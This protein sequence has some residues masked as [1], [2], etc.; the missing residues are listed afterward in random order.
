MANVRSLVWIVLAALLTST[1]PISSDNVWWD[2]AR[3]RAVCHG[4]FQPSRSLLGQS[5][6]AESDWF[7]GVPGF[8]VYSIAGGSGLMLWKLGC[9]FAIAVMLIRSVPR[10]TAGAWCVVLLLLM[11]LNDAWDDPSL[12]M[13]V[14]FVVALQRIVSRWTTRPLWTVMV[15]LVLVFV[16]WANVGER[17]VLGL[18]ALVISLTPSL[19]NPLQRSRSATVILLAILAAVANPRGWWIFRDSCVLTWPHLSESMPILK[20]AGW[21]TLIGTQPV[22]STV[23]FIVLGIVGFVGLCLA[24][25]S[26][27]EVIGC[28]LVTLSAVV[29]TTNVPFAAAWM[30]CAVLPLTQ[31]ISSTWFSRV[32]PLSMR[33]KLPGFCLTA[34]FFFAP[35]FFFALSAGS[36]WWPGSVQRFGWGIHPRLEIRLCEEALQGIDITGEVW[37]SD[38][39]AAGMIAW[40]R[41]GMLQPQVP[42]K[43]ALL[44]GRLRERMLLLQDL[45][46]SRRAWHRREDGSTGGWW[47]PLMT[48][49]TR[50]LMVSGNDQELIRALEP[51]IWRPLSLDSPV[52]PFGMAGD[53]AVNERIIEILQQ[54]DFVDLGAWTYSVPLSGG[55]DQWL[56]LWG[57][58]TGQADQTSAVQ[59]AGVFRAMNMPI[60]ALR[61]LIP[62]LSQSG[63]HPE[64]DA[65]LAKCQFQL[66]YDE[67]Q[68]LSR[69]SQWR[70][71][72]CDN[73]HRPQGFSNWEMETTEPN[74][75]AAQLQRAAGFYVQ[76]GLEEAI[77][78]LTAEDPDVQYARACLLLEAGKPAE[79]ADVLTRLLQTF[80][81]SP[82]TIVSQD[83]LFRLSP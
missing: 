45:R 80:P 76:G 65:E 64:A 15:G 7:A 68:L 52:V 19:C 13:D 79:C 33:Q 42:P 82:L 58:A 60:A 44:Q 26:R 81:D 48:R 78:L 56:D 51:T 61:V 70:Q 63:R 69:P 1:H 23:A 39:R 24:S 32:V 53:P 21:Q 54:K 75:N 16:V 28:V 34:C 57:T 77:R 73:V 20:L 72:I 10:P 29:C 67:Q 27:T 18:L 55:N 12:M 6:P 41:P 14:I 25:A 38:I 22:P 66:A 74:P 35:C 11:A 8:L 71:L 50:L 5:T 83:V 62:L 30:T 31:R 49:N 36:G 43:I 3:G 37:C 9:S 4:E 47:I 2:L 46:N 59:Q 17:I 40:L